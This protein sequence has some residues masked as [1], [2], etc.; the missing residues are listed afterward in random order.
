MTQLHKF[1]LNQNVRYHSYD[2]MRSEVRQVL[3]RGMKIVW[4]IVERMSVCLIKIKSY[5]VQ[6]KWSKE[7]VLNYVTPKLPFLIT[8]TKVCKN[9]AFSKYQKNIGKIQYMLP[10]VG[11]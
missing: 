2:K 6:V 3:R 10:H 11:K 8:L 5:F 9:V 7:T 1:S 4:K